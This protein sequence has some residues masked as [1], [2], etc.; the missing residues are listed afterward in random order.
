[1]PTPMTS[2]MHASDRSGAAA[3]PNDEAV[4]REIAQARGI[5]ESV[6][7]LIALRNERYPQSRPRYWAVVD[8]GR[9]S[10]KP[11]LF[12]LDVEAGTATAYLCAHGAGRRVHPRT[13]TPT[14]SRMFLAPRRRPS[15]SIDALRPIR[16]PTAI[17]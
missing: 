5:E 12:V 4:L 10:A 8:F 6:D 7:R 3:A 11:R 15:E 2:P 13:A 14:S 16:A 9:H 17:P 1:M